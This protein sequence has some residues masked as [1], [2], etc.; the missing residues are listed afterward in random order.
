MKNDRLV[1]N[2]ISV[3]KNK[4]FGFQE[5]VFNLLNYFYKRRDDILFE[6]III[7][8]KDTERDLFEEYRDRFEI[9]DYSYR[10]YL[11]YFFLD[12]YLPFKL[13]LGKNDLL[14]SPGNYSGW[15]KRCPEILVIHDLLYKNKNWIPSMIMRW[16]RE[17]FIPR[18]ILKADKIVAISN[19]T[20]KEVEFYYPKSKGKIEVIYNSMNFNKFNSSYIEDRP[21]YEYF[22]TIANGANYKNVKTILEAFYHYCCNGG[23]K[24]LLLVGTFKPDS[25]TS[26]Q[27]NNMPVEV[28]NRVVF[29]S[30]IS[31]AEL[32]VIYRNASCYLTASKFEGLGM[33]VVEAMSFGIPVLL[34][35]IPPHREISKGLGIY[36]SPE[37]VK[38]LTNLM[39]NMD[40]RKRD[41]DKEIRIMF[42]EENTSAKYVQL[43]NS[44]VC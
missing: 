36:F 21:S 14:F 44:F 15:F 4:A 27:L 16:Q 18:S 3:E 40:F 2:L 43:F 10:S 12:S 41:Y 42:S 24:K 5:Y 1:I 23:E 9:Y 39:S 7:L 26:K 6:R 17:L 11:G 33:P 29:K 28:R 31:N 30:H 20:K 13:R 19:F 25:D 32:G 34:S 8:C 22:L 35:D 38:E 37:N